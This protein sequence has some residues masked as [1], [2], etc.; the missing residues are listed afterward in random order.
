MLFKLLLFLYSYSDLRCVLEIDPLKKS[1]GEIANHEI[2]FLLR[3]NHSTYF[4]D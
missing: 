3:N 4:F 1:R 2:K